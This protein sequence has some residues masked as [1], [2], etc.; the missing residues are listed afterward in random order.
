MY[1][2]PCYVNL[3]ISYVNYVSIKV[4]TTYNLKWREYLCNYVSRK[5]EQPIIRNNL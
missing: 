4:K 5:P 2:D 3:D 1:L